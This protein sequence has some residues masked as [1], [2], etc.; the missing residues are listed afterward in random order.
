MS[1][2]TTPTAPVSEPQPAAKKKHRLRNA[3]LIIVGGLVLIAIAT[4]L[5]S[6]DDAATTIPSD[7]SSAAAADPTREGEDTTENAGPA[8]DDEDTAEES[9]SEQ[10]PG[11]NEPVRDGKF[12]FVVTNV[13]SGVASIGEGILEEKAQGQFI[14][15]DVTV[16]NIGDEAQYL[17]G[18]DQYLF[19]V[20]G[21]KYSGSDAAWMAL[22]DNPL[23]EEVNPG[24]KIDGTLAFDVPADVKLSELELHDS[25]F[26]DGVR[27]SVAD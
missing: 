9:P 24:N 1:T 3:F 10:L 17:S 12:E 6:G 19:D 22:E 27:V 7:D 4:N 23:L 13:E 25:M 16:E 21:K 2:E 14:I 5:G 26:S 11:L 18:S 15:I 8:L 20:D